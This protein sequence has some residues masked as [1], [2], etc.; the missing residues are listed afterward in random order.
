MLNLVQF[1]LSA[2]FGK[3]LPEATQWWQQR[4]V[5]MKT[6]GTVVRLVAAVVLIV[7]GIAVGAQMIS[8]GS[9][10]KQL[11]SQAS[12]E[13]ETGT[14]E[15]S[16]D[17]SYG[18]FVT[19]L[20]AGV[21]ILFIGLA[22]GVSGLPTVFQEGARSSSTITTPHA[23]VPQQGAAVA[24]PQSA[25]PQAAAP[26]VQPPVTQPPTEP[27]PPASSSNPPIGWK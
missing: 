1:F 2:C 18:G 13:G 6:F 5:L 4:G 8:S 7:G 23:P 3:V 17:N 10:M 11:Q 14:V 9:E 24:P 26:A 27:S 22:I 15:E 12:S 20:G 19:A 21:I 16:F 25:W